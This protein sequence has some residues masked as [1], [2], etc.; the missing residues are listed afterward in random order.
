MFHQTIIIVFDVLVLTVVWFGV[1]VAT[2]LG[3]DVSV[4]FD[5]L[6]TMYQVDR[7][8]SYY[9]LENYRVDL[10]N[11]ISEECPTLRLCA[12]HT[13]LQKLL[14]VPKSYTHPFIFA[15]IAFNIP[16][17]NDSGKP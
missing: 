11:N 17:K 4:A 13:R 14:R 8:V 6:M 10:G 9:D 7:G 5:Y 16:K 3:D 1:Y 2:L 12:R 15:K